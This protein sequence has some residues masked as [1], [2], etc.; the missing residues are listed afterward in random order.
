MNNEFLPMSLAETDGQPFDFIVVTPDA[1]VDHPSF[2]AAIIGRFVQSLG[3][4]VGVIAQPDWRVDADF[5]K[6]GTPRYAFLLSGGNMDGIVNMYTTAKRLRSEDAYSPGGKTGLRPPRPTIAYTARLKQSHKETPVIIGGVE[7]TQ[8]R[9][10]HYD[11]YEDKVRRSYLVDSK[12]DMLVFGMGERPLKDICTRLAGGENIADLTG[13]RGTC[14]LRPSLEGISEPV[15]LPPFERVETDKKA[16][17]DAFK[18]IY[19][20]GFPQGK[21]LVQAHGDRYVIQFPPSLPLSTPDMDAIYGLPFQKRAHPSYTESIPALAEVQFGITALRGCPGMCA[22]CSISAH[23]GKAIQ[24]RSKKSIVE[25]TKRIAQMRE[26]KGNISDVGGPTANFYDAIC[27]ARNSQS[28]TRT[29][30]SPSVCPNL[31][32]SHKGITEVLEAVESVPGVKRV[33]IRSGLRYDYIMADRDN[34]FFDRLV[35]KHISGQLKVAPEHVCPEVLTL[36]NKPHYG[37]YERFAKRFEGAT[38]RAG[39]PQY[40]LPYYISSHPGSTLADAIEL[41]MTLKKQGFVPDQVQ[42]FYPTPGT[43]STCMYYTGLNPLTG[44]T[45]FV[46]RTPK[47]K[48]MQRALLAFHNKKNWSLI[49]E[50]LIEAGREDLIEHGKDGLVPPEAPKQGGGK[51]RRPAAASSDADRPRK[52]ADAGRPGKRSD[53]PK[54]QFDAGKP[55]RQ[56][57]SARSGRQPDADRPNR[58]SD[59]DRPRKSADAGRPGKRSDWPKKQFD[60]GKPIKISEGQTKKQSD[61]EKPRRQSDADGS[62]KRSDWPKKPID[63]SRSNRQTNAERPTKQSNIDRPKKQFDAS[64]PS[65]QSSTNHPNRKAGGSGRQNKGKK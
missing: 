15:V 30:L 17:A 39:K 40:L 59:A 54:K 25:E 26:F 5:I 64:R 36:M 13:I 57:E 50:A 14:V 47:E 32:V 11:Y 43:L 58:Q 45:V 41:A 19:K 51:P 61:P 9:F 44:K 33:F 49:R 24:K 12:A 60:A 53:W 6:L 21:T 8:R 23:Q 46:A 52:S 1:Y 16:F 10:A 35:R 22:F 7:A 48:A 34:R 28:C 65:K 37:I 62:G 4:S 38:K 18:L 42:D 63:G 56:S 3:F 29:C 2:A 27:T 31:K 20:N 55:N